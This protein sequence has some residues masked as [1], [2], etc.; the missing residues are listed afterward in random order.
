MPQ[1]I[2]RA[3]FFELLVR[4]ALF[5]FKENAPKGTIMTTIECVEKLVIDKIKPN[6]ETVPW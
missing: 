1:D 5:K 6:I 3:E 4:V 2:N